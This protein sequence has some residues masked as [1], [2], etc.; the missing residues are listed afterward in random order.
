LT[1]CHTEAAQPCPACGERKYRVLFRETDRLYR[2]TTRDFEVVECGGCRL[3]RLHPWPSDAELRTYYPDDYW[4]APSPGAA[5]RLE[6]FYRRIVLRDHLHFVRTAIQNAGG[7]GLVLDVGCGGGLFLGMLAASGVR[8]A[9]LD[10]SWNAAR[11]AWTQK[12]APAVCADLARAPFAPQSCAVITMFHVM[13]HLYNPAAYLTAARQLLQPEGRLVVQVP[14]ASSW[15]F[16]VF[17]KR[18]SGI[19]V[20]RHLI[21]FRQRDLDRLL[22]ECGFEPV[23]YKHFSL[24]DN[25]AGLATT[26]APSLDPMA[27]RIRRTGESSGARLLK[28]LVYMA[29]VMASVPFAVAEAA[30]GAGS[31]IM[32][33]ARKKR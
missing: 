30:C 26:L 31:T 29:L 4:F 28:D 16:R 1:N 25:P 7:S 21:D 27:R 12:G 33:E 23:R 15:Q 10:F 8:I 13:E 11:I 24:R 22:D 18:W 14:N 6:E 19:D 32:V 5:E 2:T 17:G 9:G 3:I 20:P